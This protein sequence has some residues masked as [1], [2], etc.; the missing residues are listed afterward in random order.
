M[1]V[2][3]RAVNKAESKRTEA[4]ELDILGDEDCDENG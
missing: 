3:G 1:T 2:E 4:E